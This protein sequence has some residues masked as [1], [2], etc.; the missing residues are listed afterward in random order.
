MSRQ[1]LPCRDRVLRPGTRLCLGS[2]DR[3]ALVVGTR[4]LQSFLA[5]C[6]DKDL[7][8]V[9]GFLGILGCLGSDRGFLY[10]DIDFLA[11]C[12]CRNFVL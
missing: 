8:V 1:S 11:L 3:H 6:R 5:L 12:H 4:S 9:I 10:R 7:H 2:R